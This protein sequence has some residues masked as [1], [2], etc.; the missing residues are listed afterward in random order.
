MCLS[1][2]V[3]YQCSVDTI[4][5]ADTLRWRVLDATNN[6]VG[7][8]PFSQGQTPTKSPVGSGF[9][10]TLTDSS[11]PIVSSVSFTSSLNISNYTIECSA[12]GTGSYTPVTCPI[13]IA[14]R[15]LKFLF[16]Q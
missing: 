1:Q 10:A 6:L 9:T 15:I 8:V 5:G 11:G 2:S 4:G 16:N 3:S 14:G 13:L 7:V 12:S